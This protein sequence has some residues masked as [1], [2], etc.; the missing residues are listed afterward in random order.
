M[1]TIV[2]LF[3]SILSIRVFSRMYGRIVRLRRP[4]FIIKRLIKLFHKTYEIDMNE[5]EGEVGDYKSLC[6]FF[7]RRLDPRKR[8]LIPVENAIVSPV[9]GKMTEIETI[10]SDQATQVKGKTYSITQL[11][12]ETIDFSEGWHVAVIYL[13]PSNYHRYHY[14]IAGNISRYLHTGSRLYPVNHWGLNLIDRLFIRNER[15]VTEIETQQNGA[16]TRS[17][18]VAVGATFVG[19]IKM[20]FIAE[21]K[22]RGQWIPINKT[23]KQL[24][25]KGRFEKGSTIV[26]VVPKKMA[27]PIPD[28]KGQTVRVG[29]PLLKLLT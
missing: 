20:E 19:S 29:D 6:D 16:I 13:S 4:R 25:E 21:Q 26:M 12:G 18:I 8:P 2:K 9:D 5:Y 1:K 17:Y 3:L 7:T 15:I 28:K 14:P 22:K 27:E 10:F 24:E 23:V 11:I